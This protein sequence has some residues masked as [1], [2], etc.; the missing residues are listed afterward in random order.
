[1]EVKQALG[2]SS[3]ARPALMNPEPESITTAAISISEA[4]CQERI[5]W[6]IF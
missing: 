2:A 4:I 5:D 6:G 1:M 3:P